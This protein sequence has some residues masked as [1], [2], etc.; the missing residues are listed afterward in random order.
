[1]A[2][3]LR[4]AGHWAEIVDRDWRLVYSTEDLRR[5]Y[6]GLVDLVPVALGAHYF[7]SEAMSVRLQ[8]RNGPNTLELVREMF[9]AFGGSVLADTAG[10]R[11]QLRTLVSPELRDIV[12]RISSPDLAPALTLRW[13]GTH[14]G[15]PVD[16]LTTTVRVH[17]TAGRRAGTALISKPRA[18]SI[19][20][21]PN[22]STISCFSR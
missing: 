11:D 4:D 13:H 14:L 22:P 3:A 9:A 18:R 8:W 6:G 17:D 21:P 19:R 5:I 7:G 12:D 10:G 2:A 15:A 16:V 1:M 20:T